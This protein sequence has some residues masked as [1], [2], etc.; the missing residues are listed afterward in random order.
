MAEIDLRGVSLTY[1]VYGAEARS[2][3]SVAASVGTGGLIR[4]T[5]ARVEIC[6][7]NGINL[8]ACDGDRIGILGHNG[9][10]KTT[11]LKVLAGILRPQRGSIRRY[12]TT[13]AVLN[14]SIGLDPNL[15]GY[16]NVEQIALLYGLS[17][18]QIEAMKP[19]IADFA[20]LGDFMALP[21]STYSA[22]MKT[23]LGF[24]VATAFRPE[25]LVAD[26]NL[27]T[28]DAN[29]IEKARG[30]MEAMMADASILV[31][32]SHSVTTLRKLCNRAILMEHGEIVV[33]G[34]P[35]AVI[36]R[37]NGRKVPAAQVG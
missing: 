22:G 14:P 27:G 35:G 36:E 18:H 9:A 30:R 33:D 2:F 5:R 20:E 7:L 26:E 28:G 6:A 23:R 15:S 12:G 24:A 32:A 31:V 16:Q 10:G 17:R 25:I 4:R 3:K 34:E 13:M 8:A 11:L 21:L 1:P 19:D 29:F 37:Y